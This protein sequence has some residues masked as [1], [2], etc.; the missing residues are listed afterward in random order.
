MWRRGSLLLLLLLLA[1]GAVVLLR[2]PDPRAPE[3]RQESREPQPVEV[4]TTD[5]PEVADVQRVEEGPVA[6][7]AADPPPPPPPEL[8]GAPE[9]ALPPPEQPTPLPFASGW[10]EDPDGNRLEDVVV[11]AHCTKPFGPHGRWVEVA[12]PVS[13][14]LD[15]I[16]RSNGDGAFS[17][18]S[19]PE[20]F[21]SL[22]FVK[23]GWAATEVRGLS[24]DPEDNQDLL[25][26]LEP[27]RRLAGVVQDREG[28]P[29]NGARVKFI[30]DIPGP[31]QR[32]QATTG[33]EGRYAF[34]C[35][36]RVEGAAYASAFGYDS[37]DPH[38]VR[39]DPDVTEYDFT[40]RRVQ[41]LMD[42]SDASTKA[43]IPDARGVVLDASDGTFV[44]LLVPIQRWS[45]VRAR[46][47]IVPLGR[48]TGQFPF[49][50]ARR[51]VQVVDL[52][53]FAPGYVPAVE[54]F[55]S[56]NT[57]RPPHL[58]VCLQ[59]GDT[60]VALAGTVVDAP[61]AIVE[62]RAR[63]PRYGAPWEHMLHLMCRQTT[64]EQGRF[65]FRGLPPGPY[66]MLIEAEDRGSVALDVEAPAENLR[67]ESKRS[68][69]LIVK[70]VSATG[71]PVPGTWITLDSREVRLRWQKQT[72]PDGVA[73]FE[74]LPPGRVVFLAAKP[75]RFS[76][77]IDSR[78]RFA[79]EIDLPAGETV[80]AEIQAP[81]HVETTFL[82]R[83]DSGRP[84]MGIGLRLGYIHPYASTV[85]EWR[86]VDALRPVTDADGR[87]TLELFPGGYE[88]WIDGAA[89]A[90]TLRRRFDVG[91]SSGGHV[92]IVTPTGTCVLFGRVVERGSG[93]PVA[94]RPVY[95]HSPDDGYVL[96]RA[97]LDA[98]GMYEIRGLHPGTVQVVLDLRADGEGVLSVHTTDEGVVELRSPYPMVQAEAVLRHG[99]RSEVSIAVPRVRGPGSAERPYELE[100][101]VR[102]SERGLPVK[103]AQG[104]VEGWLDGMWIEAGQF[105]TDARGSATAALLAA[106]RYR[107]HVHGPRTKGEPR[108]ERKHIELAA[109]GRH[110]VL[111]VELTP[112]G[113]AD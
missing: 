6:S 76:L 75:Q 73:P 44:G 64:D 57:R 95:V 9:A 31:K 105:E 74:G 17:V 1:V 109:S 102:D 19:M 59:P 25:V 29:I 72:G 38:T 54:R 3:P 71:D 45:P 107:V 60:P 33:V 47:D 86:R 50:G 55:D 63:E 12:I 36:P 78:F 22:A 111:E 42:V 41:F 32:L 40:L 56:R 23:A 98:N 97:V 21:V 7:E 30:P 15:E 101:A 28:L 93:R 24:E 34:E 43:P 66:R 110:G 37:E 94:G 49:R 8:R 65:A 88:C 39:I 104:N 81:R 84:R 51:P 46:R 83:D 2:N 18:A 113:E 4:A 13:G 48:L 58:R 52:H 53:L 11:L 14:E 61:G 5:E 91:L 103:G 112:V 67:I 100:V 20:H 70:A 79:R 106:E 82:V 62:V 99:R 16:A 89:A 26:V 10:V 69:N 35:L 92:E 27:G 96:G 68:A 85:G 80:E 108:Y 87:V 90:N 77:P